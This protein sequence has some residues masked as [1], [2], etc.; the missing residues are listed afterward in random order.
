MLEIPVNKTDTNLHVKI[1]GYVDE[2]IL[3]TPNDGQWVQ[4]QNKKKE[5]KYQNKQICNHNDCPNST[6]QYTCAFFGLCKSKIWFYVILYMLNFIF[7]CKL[8]FDRRRK[9]VALKKKKAQSEEGK[10]I[11]VKDWLKVCSSPPFS[12]ENCFITFMQ[13]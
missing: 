7:Y 10:N 8:L 13:N 1:Q 6:H 3:S 9:M 11:T 4:L 12:L 5:N 2:A